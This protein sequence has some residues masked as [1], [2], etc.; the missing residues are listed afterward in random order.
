MCMQAMNVNVLVDSLSYHQDHCD[1][2]QLAMILVAMLAAA[3]HEVQ[4]QFERLFVVLL[5]GPDQHL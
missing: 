5:H 1:P 3:Q 2:I 4:V